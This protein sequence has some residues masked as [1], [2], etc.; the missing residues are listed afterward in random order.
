MLQRL[1]E[2]ANN[3]LGQ[4]VWVLEKGHVVTGLQ[5]ENLRQTLFKELVVAYD[6]VCTCGA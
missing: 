1:F 6:L 3:E 2:K 5:N 4:L